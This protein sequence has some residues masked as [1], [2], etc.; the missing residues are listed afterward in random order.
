M[1][2]IV[3]SKTTISSGKCEKCEQ[4]SWSNLG[5]NKTIKCNKCGAIY[6]VVSEHCRESNIDLE[7]E[8]SEFHCTKTELGGST[9]QNICPAQNMFC[10]KHLS[11]SCYDLTKGCIQYYENI[12]ATQKAELDKMDESKRLW[13]IQELS[14][15]DNKQ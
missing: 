12:V 11:E 6:K 8:F 1:T 7:C 4:S 13:L 14:G 9:C 15:I 2:L 3:E 10:L 5:F